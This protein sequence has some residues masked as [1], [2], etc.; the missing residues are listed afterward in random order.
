MTKLIVVFRNFVKA[1]KTYRTKVGKL[2]RKSPP[3]DPASRRSFLSKWGSQTPRILK[4][5]VGSF[6]LDSALLT[7]VSILNSF[8]DIWE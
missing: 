1:H 4:F 3:D 7:K 8:C 5:V 2:K 6:R